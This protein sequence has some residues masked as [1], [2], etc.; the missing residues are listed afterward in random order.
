MHHLG[1]VGSQGARCVEAGSVADNDHRLP[2]APADFHGQGDGLVGRL[3]GDD[4]LEQRHLL[5]RREVVHADDI[6][7]PPRLRGDVGDGDRRGIGG[8]DRLAAGRIF[9]RGKDRLLQGE[10]LKDGLDDEAG[11]LHVGDLG[12]RREQP[13]IAL[14]GA[15]R[16]SGRDLDLLFDVG[17]SFRR[18][19]GVDFGDDG[20][21]LRPRHGDRRNT[22]AHETATD[23]RNLRDVLPGSR[24]TGL[25]LLH[26]EEQ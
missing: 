10:V 5:D 21:Y 26:R 24:P 22:G 7:R 3:L 11:A 23:H 12:G 25:V 18:C 14:G 16:L 6:A 13:A 15:S 4:H 9:D 1:S 19:F 2:L 20:R 8:E 17:D